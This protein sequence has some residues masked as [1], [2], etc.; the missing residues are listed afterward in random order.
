MHGSTVGDDERCRHELPTYVGRDGGAAVCDRLGGT[1][2]G[3]DNAGQRHAKGASGSKTGVSWS[4]HKW[5]IDRTWL[6]GRCLLVIPVF[7]IEGLDLSVF[8]GDYS[9]GVHSSLLCSACHAL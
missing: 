9:A 5:G 2:D 4:C 7:L 8:T 6:A 3:Y 1:A